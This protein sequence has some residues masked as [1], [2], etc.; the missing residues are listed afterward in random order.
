MAAHAFEEKRNERGMVLPR[1]VGENSRENLLAY[2][3]PRFG[4]ICIPAM[5]IFTCGFFAFTRS[6]MAWRFAFICATGR[7]RSPSFAP[8]S[9]TSTS[10]C[11]CKTQSSRRK[12][13]AVVSPLMPALITS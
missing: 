12:P 3:P 2:S 10:I 1:E 6:M 13:P 5:T 11:F 8:S 7:P 9:R 4:G